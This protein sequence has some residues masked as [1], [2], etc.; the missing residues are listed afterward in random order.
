MRPALPVLRFAAKRLVDPKNRLPHLALVNPIPTLSST[1]ALTSSS[2]STLSFHVFCYARTA[3]GCSGFPSSLRTHV[4]ES[5]HEGTRSQLAPA[6]S[7]TESELQ[8]AGFALRVLLC[9]CCCCCCLCPG[10]FDTLREGG[11]EAGRND[12]YLKLQRCTSALLDCTTAAAAQ[13]EAV[14]C[15]RNSRAKASL[16][17]LG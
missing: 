5:K 10:C 12:A 14:G 3:N 16:N 4:E 1:S 9:C 2:R 6:D 17:G 15:I 7:I 11:T 13:R 8:L